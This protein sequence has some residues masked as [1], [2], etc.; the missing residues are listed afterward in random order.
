MKQ[1][2]LE[3]GI[4]A[5]VLACCVSLTQATQE[6]GHESSCD[7]SGD[8]SVLRLVVTFFKVGVWCLKGWA[9]LFSEESGA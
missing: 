7:D 9:W 4:A 5:A 8:L 1:L 2:P 3:R 6:G